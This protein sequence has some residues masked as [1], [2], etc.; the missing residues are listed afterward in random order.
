MVNRVLV[1]DLSHRLPDSTVIS[2]TGAISGTPDATVSINVLRFD[3][4]RSGVEVLDAQISISGDRSVT[5]RVHLTV[6]LA[7]HTRRRWSAR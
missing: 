6:P 4:D 5:Q 2:E 7:D 1:Q 3:A